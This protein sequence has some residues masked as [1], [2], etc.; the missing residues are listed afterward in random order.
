MG[1][2]RILISE[3][4]VGISDFLFIG[5]LTVDVSEPGFGEIFWFKGFCLNQNLQ[6]LRISRMVAS[7]IDLLRSSVMSA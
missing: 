1:K 2:D 4:G 6:N 5:I 3:L 7:Y